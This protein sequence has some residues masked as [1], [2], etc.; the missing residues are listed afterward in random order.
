MFE[1]QIVPAAADSARE[2]GALRVPAWP[3]L[4]ARLA[5][6]HDL[7]RAMARAGSY[8]AGNFACFG[9]CGEG[10]SG[11]GEPLVNPDGLM[12]GKGPGGM[13]FAAANGAVMAS[14]ETR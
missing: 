12:H 4:V 5:A 14:R 10:V 1:G 11:E 3:E 7:R 2:G 6:A 9:E 13:A 8:P